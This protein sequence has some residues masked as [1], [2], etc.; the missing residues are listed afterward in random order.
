MAKAM[1]KRAVQRNEVAKLNRTAI[2]IGGCAAG[3]VL[4]VVII[5]FL[6]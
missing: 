3:A 2:M 6:S 5:S 4:L 1:G